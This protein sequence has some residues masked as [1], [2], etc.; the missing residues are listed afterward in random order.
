[1]EGVMMDTMYRIPSD[2]TIEQ[3][4]ITKDAVDGKSEPV[5]LHKGERRESLETAI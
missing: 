5:V 2:D 4:V 3:C 1:M